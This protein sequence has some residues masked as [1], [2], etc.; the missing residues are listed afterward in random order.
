MGVEFSI[1]M[2]ELTDVKLSSVTKADWQAYCHHVK[3]HVIKGM[4]SF[5]M[6]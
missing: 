6:L 1:K 5:L 2:C 4:A 3:K